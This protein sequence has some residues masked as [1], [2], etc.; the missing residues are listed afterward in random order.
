[1]LRCLKHTNKIERR[2]NLIHAYRVVY[3]HP[4][5]SIMCCSSKLEKTDFKSVNILAVR[6]RKVGWIHAV[7]FSLSLSK[8]GL[9][10][11]LF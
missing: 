2:V 4:C 7:A 5:S 6:I 3:M 8:I 11:F 10:L 1:M 9:A